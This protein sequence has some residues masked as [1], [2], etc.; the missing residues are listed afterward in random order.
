MKNLALFSSKDK[1]KKL[2]CRQ[3]HFLFGALRVNAIT[4]GKLFG[5][6]E[7][8][9]F[10]CQWLSLFHCHFLFILRRDVYMS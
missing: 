6:L 5:P 7:L 4:H 2:K 1:N 3:L 10:I 9:E 8:D